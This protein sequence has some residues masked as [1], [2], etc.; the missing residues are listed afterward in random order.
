[1]SRVPQFQAPPLDVD[2][3]SDAACSFDQNPFSTQ[4][5]PADVQLPSQAR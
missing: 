4:I 2:P 5:E 3:R 1:M